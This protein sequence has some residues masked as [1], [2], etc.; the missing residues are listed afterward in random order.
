MSDNN[1]GTRIYP[2]EDPNCR[3][4]YLVVDVKRAEKN[5]QI[6]DVLWANYWCE[7]CREHGSTSSA[8]S[9]RVPDHFLPAN[10]SVRLYN[11]DLDERLKVY[12]YSTDDK[13]QI[14]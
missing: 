13:G 11:P 14:V 6:G 3:H 12:L 4:L 8:E 1:N 2:G 10:A 5:A 9:G 7:D